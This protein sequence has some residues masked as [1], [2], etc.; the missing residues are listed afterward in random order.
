M[1]N[2]YEN[3]HSGSIVCEKHLGYEASAHFGAKPNAKSFKTSFGTIRRMTT[4]DAQEWVGIVGDRYPNGC[5][6]CR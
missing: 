2:L 4:A 3:T 5:E 1:H 6:C